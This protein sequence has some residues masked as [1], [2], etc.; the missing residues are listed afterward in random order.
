MSGQQ[1]TQHREENNLLGP[2]LVA[3]MV[4]DKQIPPDENSPDHIST[5]RHLRQHL[6]VK[7]KFLTHEQTAR[8]QA[9]QL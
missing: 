3:S 5:A 6:W 4:Q 8:S 2:S 7:Q 1:P 9:Q